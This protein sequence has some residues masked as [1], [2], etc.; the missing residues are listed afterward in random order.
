MRA[1]H[2][3]AMKTVSKNTAQQVA[4]AR[5]IGGALGGQG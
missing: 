3:S 5:R 2:E 1:P 4:I